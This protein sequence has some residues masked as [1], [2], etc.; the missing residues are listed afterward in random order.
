MAGYCRKPIR[1]TLLAYLLYIYT[2]GSS[3]QQ[4]KENQLCSV[5]K[6]QGLCIDSMQCSQGVSHCCHHRP[7]TGDHPPV[8]LKQDVTISKP[9]A[10]LYCIFWPIMVS[11]PTDLS[12]GGIRCEKRVLYAFRSRALFIWESCM[13]SRP[14]DTKSFP[15]VTM[16]CNHTYFSNDKNNSNRQQKPG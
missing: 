1:H 6:G 7:R 3:R 9:A 8:H 2:I 16:L 11:K 12:M 15:S 13:N 14:V 4:Q 5:R 10:I